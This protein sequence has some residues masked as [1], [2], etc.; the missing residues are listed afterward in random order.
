MNKKSVAC[1][2]NEKQLQQAA[3]KTLRIHNRKFVIEYVAIGFI[4]ALNT[5]VQ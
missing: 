4:R 1:V 5:K 3:L 2:E